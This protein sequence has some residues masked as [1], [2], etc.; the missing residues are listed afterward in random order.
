MQFCCIH[1]TAYARNIILSKGMAVYSSILTKH[2]KRLASTCVGTLAS[3]KSSSKM[4]VLGRE[5]VFIMP[6][7]PYENIYLYMNR[8]FC[9]QFINDIKKTLGK[10]FTIL[11]MRSY[12]KLISLDSQV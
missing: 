3:T 10:T 1:Y 8:D 4:N 9:F 12:F 7:A 5:T 6:Y 2:F 11:Y